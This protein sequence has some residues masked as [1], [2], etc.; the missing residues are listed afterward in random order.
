GGPAF[1]LSAF[2]EQD[3]FVVA[4]RGAAAEQVT[5]AVHVIR[6]ADWWPV[7]LLAQRWH[8]IGR[9]FTAVLA[10]PLVRSQYFSGV[11]CK[12]QRVVQLVELTVFH[13]G[14]LAA[15]G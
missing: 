14:D 3:L 12:L 7:L 2:P 1:L 15:D 13:F 11:R 6:A 4:D 5:V 9:H 8:R 10:F